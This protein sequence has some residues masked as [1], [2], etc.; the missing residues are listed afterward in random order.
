MIV[1]LESLVNG[2]MV[3]VA[4]THLLFSPKKP[5]TRL[6]QTVMLLAEIDRMAWI[7]ESSLHNQTHQVLY[8][9]NTN[10][11]PAKRQFVLS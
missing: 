5:E 7:G 11:P 4:T 2:A 6:A 1:V 3:C 8:N 9:L 10:F